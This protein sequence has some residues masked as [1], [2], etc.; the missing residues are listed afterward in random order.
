MDSRQSSSV[1]RC[2]A[3]LNP[4]PRVLAVALVIY[5]W[6]TSTSSKEPFVY[7]DVAVL[8][9]DTPVTGTVVFEQL[10]QSS[11]ITVTGESLDLLASLGFHI[12]GAAQRFRSISAYH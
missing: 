12:Q 9:G 8:S 5:L 1:S 10:S 11:P 6:A 4:G 3:P 2:T 7:R